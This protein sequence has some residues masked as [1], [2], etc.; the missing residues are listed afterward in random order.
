MSTDEFPV[1]FPC[2]GASLVG[3][4]HPAKHPAR[5]G[6][7]I[8]VGGPQYRVGSHRQFVLLARAL[9]AA[10]IP[11]FRFDVRGMGDSGGS[12]PGF[13]SLD[14]DIAAAIDRF[15]ASCPEIR[16]VALWGLCDAASAI[17]LYAHRDPRVAG[18]ALLNPWVRTE[19]T[20]ARTELRYYYAGKITDREFWCRFLTGGVR[21][22][23][24]ARSFRQRVRA[25]TQF[26]RAATRPGLPI[27]D[28][29]DPSAPLP[30][31]M[32]QGLA[33]FGG[34]VLLIIS[35]NDLTAR[36]F[37]D[38]ARAS[39]RWSELLSCES[40]HRQDLKAADHTFSRAEWTEAVNA[41]TIAWV[42][43]LNR[44]KRPQERERAASN[45]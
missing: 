4:V 21:M 32:A 41:W 9:A 8:V 15:V 18:I 11:A 7:V 44:A 34:P 3:I 37:D 23:D 33:A 13:E 27:G 39:P 25:A 45:G 42:E 20:Y 5:T 31:R 2:N 26:R 17:L 38:V 14:D 43:G 30:D 36:E 22:Y 19:T 6:V 28:V 16:E 40:V 12:F 10:G 1:C 35:G 29:I 24:A